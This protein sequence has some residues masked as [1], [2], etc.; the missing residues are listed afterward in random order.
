MSEHQA[1]GYY[2]P[3]PSSWPI[4][5]SAALALL[6]SGL[7]MW[8]NDISP[9]GWLM[10]AGLLVLFYMMFGWFGEVIAESQSGKYNP[11]VD[12][13]YR[14]GM[15]WFIFSEVMFFAA[16]FGALFY[17]RI[18]SVPWLGEGDTNAV[19]WEGFK[20]T[21]PTTNA[22]A[23]CPVAASPR[24]ARTPPGQTLREGIGR[25]GTGCEREAWKGQQ[26]H[27]EPRS[28]KTSSSTISRVSR[29]SS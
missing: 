19:L 29:Q 16:F 12:L 18:L 14:W 4:V 22:A 3:E 2:V 15:S 24:R 5:G 23:G 8:A 26:S 17:M 1:G 10:L 9:G 20:A 7:V 25:S 21:W 6:M 13:S 11:Q 27:H 28:Q